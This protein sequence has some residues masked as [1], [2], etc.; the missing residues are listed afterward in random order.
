MNKSAFDDENEFFILSAGD[1]VEYEII[2]GIFNE[3][4]TRIIEF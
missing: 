1:L 4:Q 3:R 2:K